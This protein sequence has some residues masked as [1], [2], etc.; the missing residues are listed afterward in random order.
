[1]ELSRENIWG[2]IDN[3]FNE[4]SIEKGCL[5][6]VSTPIGNLDDIS[7]RALF[8]LK[9]VDYV[10]SEDTRVTGILLKEYGIQTKQISYFAQVEQKK[11]DDLIGKLK[12][13]NS[14]A[15]V[16]DAGT[17][18]IS[19]PGNILVSK[20]IEEGI[21]VRS[22][23]G[24]SSLIHSI[25]V[26]G[27]NSSKFYFQGFLPQKKGRSGIL[28]ELK[29]IKMP[30]VI[31]ESKYKMSKTLNDLLKVFGNKEVSISRELTKKFEET[32]RGRLKDIVKQQLKLKGE[33]VIIIN[34]N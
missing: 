29:E 4:L 12:D 34:N 2:Y 6:V 31:F 30:I 13:G 1:M 18:G 20:C 21:E 32:L 11:L 8:I 10:A 7:F 24:A 22:I 19:D 26:S 15:L 3:K 17:P 27:F 14:I 33:F 23:P 25:V 9:N 5:Y 28:D 16:S